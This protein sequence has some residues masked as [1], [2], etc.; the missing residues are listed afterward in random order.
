MKA[1]IWIISLIFT[2]GIGERSASA[3][4]VSSVSMGFCSLTH[5]V[6]KLKEYRGVIRKACEFQHAQPQRTMIC[7][8]N[9]ALCH[10]KTVLWGY[11]E[12]TDTDRAADRRFLKDVKGLALSTRS[13]INLESSYR[14]G[15]YG[16]RYHAIEFDYRNKNNWRFIALNQDAASNLLY[17]Y[18]WIVNLPQKIIR[19]YY[20][21]MNTKQP[22]LI[23][24]L[25]IS[26]L[27]IPV[28]FAVMAVCTMVGVIYGAITQPINTI[29][30]IPGG[31]WLGLLSTFHAVVD[32]II[33]IPKAIW[34]TLTIFF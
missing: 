32:T 27:L 10:Q 21:I 12:H 22:S 13:D 6:A 30:G 33:F 1:L 23:I 2:L 29:I 34:A 18:T 15:T 25:I 20:Y 9:N 8:S 11:S 16:I 17:A 3:G 26:L 5:P 24:D 19:H 28:D 31:L 14:L 7:Q 4:V